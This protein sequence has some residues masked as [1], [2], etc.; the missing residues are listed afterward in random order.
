M[1]FAHTLSHFF[2]SIFDLGIR[3][4]ELMRNMCLLGEVL[5]NLF[6]LGINLKMGIKFL[7]DLIGSS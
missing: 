1:K 2:P 4:G 6:F 7:Y 3:E 5:P